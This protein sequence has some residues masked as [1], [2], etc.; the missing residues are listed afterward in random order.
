MH[1][2]NAKE[3]PILEILLQNTSSILKELNKDNTIITNNSLRDELSADL[4]MYIDLINN[5]LHFRNNPRDRSGLEKAN[6]IKSWLEQFGVNS[7]IIKLDNID[8]TK[9]ANADNSWYVI[10]VILGDTSKG[11]KTLVCVHHDTVA[12]K[13]SKIQFTEDTSNGYSISHPWLIDVTVQLASILYTIVKI[14]NTII[15][16]KTSSNT[17]NEEIKKVIGSITFLITDG[18]EVN[19]L[20]MRSWLSSNESSHN[21]KPY[22]F[23]LICEP[24]GRGKTGSEIVN[25]FSNK[26]FDGE[27]PRVCYSN[28]GKATGIITTEGMD[29]GLFDIFVSFTKIFRP[30]QKIIYSKS[31]NSQNTIKVDESLFPTAVS[32]TVA[33]FEKSSSNIFFEARTNEVIGVN[34][35]LKILKDNANNYLNSYEEVNVTDLTKNDMPIK[36]DINGIS[37]LHSNDK[38]IIN[39]KNGV[40]IH[41][42]NYNPYSRDN[43]HIA[44]ELILLNLAKEDIPNI[45]KI[46]IGDANKPNTVP[47]E[48]F[49]TFEML[50][51]IVTLK[52]NLL[53]TKAN[54]DQQLQTLYKRDDNTDLSTKIKW[55]L[56]EDPN[57]PPR[58][59][60][61]VDEASWDIVNSS[62]DILSS[63]ISNLFNLN[64]C[65]VKIGV[66]NAMTDIGPTTYPENSWIW[67]NDKDNSKHFPV[68]TLGVGDFSKVHNDNEPLSANE[69]LITM[70]LYKDILI[71]KLFQN[72]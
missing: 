29:Q 41:P 35:T 67:K 5:L 60:V 69:L 30:I 21:F 57:I 25:V 19:T 1:F 20:G 10:E 12:K 42:G 4:P 49:I 55:T 63:A 43:A 17:T 45:S 44:V 68:I 7:K 2:S 32:F 3:N 50:P 61:Q 56:L 15:S 37:L 36:L 52:D 64:N 40:N 53:K 70:I 71:S 38:Y 51:D 62:R 58:E 6:F 46:T 28:R 22:D 48:A 8:Q 16:T 18:E 65:S 34:E 72:N 26:L 24:S 13:E 47:S 33:S 9:K 31:S 59:V 66:F 54:W 27:I 23:I 11:D 39:I 14:N